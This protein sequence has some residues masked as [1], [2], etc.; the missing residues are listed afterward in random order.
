[1][2][3]GNEINEEDVEYLTGL[4]DEALSTSLARYE[5][6]K[7][8]LPQS[9]AEVIGDSLAKLYLF[10]MVRDRHLL[11]FDS[12]RPLLPVFRRASKR[13]H[14]ASAIAYMITGSG[15]NKP[16]PPCWVNL[17]SGRAEENE[18]DGAIRRQ[19][20]VRRVDRSNREVAK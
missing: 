3:V 20:N 9:E 11:P 18:S 12:L 1:M 13:S 17:M 16:L 19:G 14:S 5:E 6:M 7:T 4:I 10:L 8:R 15:L 2:I